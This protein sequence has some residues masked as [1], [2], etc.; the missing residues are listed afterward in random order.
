MTSLNSVWGVI[1]AFHPD[2]LGPAVTR[3]ISQ[4]TGVVVV[5]DGS[6]AGAEQQLSVA[7][8]AGAEVVAL[9]HNVGIAAALNVGVRHALALG[10]DAVVTF[11]QDS[12]VPS[13]FVKRLRELH[14]E[15]SQTVQ[16]PVV[17]VPQYFASVDQTVHRGRG[18][19]LS[20]RNAIQSGMLIP[21]DVVEKVGFFREELFI[22]LVDTEYALRCE[23]AG[24]FAY[25]VPGLR[26]EHH[27]GGRY[28]PRGALLHRVGVVTLSSPFRYYY[29][30]RNR[31]LIEKDYLRHF[32]ARLLRDGIID[33]LHF[34]FALLLSRPRRTM[35]RVLRTGARDGRRG[36]GGRIP[37]AEAALA[38]TIS[39]RAVLHEDS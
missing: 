31:T 20:A 17:V 6:G 11:D 32:P 8:A 10:A 19:P 34:A 21:H 12:S 7:R 9:P 38:R 13:D 35:W 37:P 28:R 30:V 36:V 24:V 29:R 3:L 27:L 26:L 23:V 22:D 15:V 4:T 5:D 33:R 2:D 14:D 25:G 39:W 1:T 16:A 18:A